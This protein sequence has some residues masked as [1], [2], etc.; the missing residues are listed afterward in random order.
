LLAAAAARHSRNTPPHLRR[1]GRR[2]DVRVDLRELPRARRQPDRRYRLGPRAVRRALTDNEL[3]GIIE[4]GIPNTAMPPSPNLGGA[5]GAR[6]RVLARERR[7]ETDRRI[8]R[9]RR[10]RQSAVRRQGRVQG[11]SSR[12]RA[13]LGA[14]TGPEHDRRLRR[15]LEIEQSLLEPT[16]EVQANNRF[17]RVVTADGKE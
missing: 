16:A 11:L 10:A 3:A 6:R 5:G 15:A 13:R 7:S 4:N 12:R 17:Y 1:R 14:P 2:P 9:Q 8:H